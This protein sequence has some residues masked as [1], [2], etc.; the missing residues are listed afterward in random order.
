MAKNRKNAQN[1]T[2]A[3]GQLW[4]RLD[5]GEKHQII[6]FLKNNPKDSMSRVAKIFAARLNK[7]VN[8]MSYTKR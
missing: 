8:K 6:T 1:R 2:P 3:P 7:K 4:F 5:M